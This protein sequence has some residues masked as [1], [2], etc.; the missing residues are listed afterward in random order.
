[1]VKGKS[2]K[3]DIIAETS[4]SAE[5]ESVDDFKRVNESIK[6]ISCMID[7]LKPKGT[8]ET[9]VKLVL[10]ALSKHVEVLSTNCSTMSAC[11]DTVESNLAKMDQYSRRSTVLVTGLD[12]HKESETYQYL[13][14]NV[15]SELSKSGVKVS[16]S[17]F[18][19]CHRN[20][21]KI[22]TVKRS[23]REIKTPPSITVKFVNANKKDCVLK[24]YK[25]FEGG[26]PK[27]LKVCS[28]SIINY[29]EL[30]YNISNLCRE[31]GDKVLWIHWRSSSS[32]LCIK[33]EDGRYFAKVHSM[34][35]FTNRYFS[36]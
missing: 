32:G 11:V 28:P 31:N 27:E 5:I 7:N 30:K 24:G 22:K 12:Y 13:S 9:Q 33:L 15:A 23:G 36:G 10:Q 21:N 6:E 17:D 14:E 3:T 34:K 1:M 16:N 26:K 20:G 25:N 2:P 35:D 8:F 18:A 29:Q 19:A 4:S